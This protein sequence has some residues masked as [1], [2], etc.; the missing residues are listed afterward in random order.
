MGYTA[1][2]FQHAVQFWFDRGWLKPGQRLIDFGSQEFFADPVET[3]RAVTAFLGQH[4]VSADTIKAPINRGG[5]LKAIYA[6]VGIDYASID[7]DGA[8]GSEFFDLNSFEA[9]PKWRNAFDFVNNEGTIEHLANPINGFHV[10]HDIAKVGGVIRHNFPLI[11]WYQHGFAN[12][13]TKF[14]AHL[15][16]DNAYELLKVQATV[17][18]PTPFNDPLFTTCSALTGSVDSPTEPIPPPL[19]TNIWGELVYRKTVDRP[20]IL[21]VDH[22]DGPN[23]QSVRRRL[24]EN[25]HRIR[26]LRE[27][28]APQ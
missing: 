13:T 25:F 28:D 17:T 6:A 15:I 16:G 2:Y 14:Y 27:L 7:V 24:N 8:H 4:G 12:L 19:V 22:V 11:G 3:T 18:E 1:L 5:A 21:P 26:L 23:A 9:P 20:F 10:A